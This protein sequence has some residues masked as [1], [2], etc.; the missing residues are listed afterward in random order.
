MDQAARNNIPCDQ[1]ME[2]F[3]QDG[4]HRYFFPDVRSAFVTVYYVDGT[5]ESIVTALATGRAAVADL[6]RFGISYIVDP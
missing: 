5:E 2:L 1:M 3:Y 6:D 4:E